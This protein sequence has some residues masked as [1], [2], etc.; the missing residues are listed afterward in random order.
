MKRI[1]VSSMMRKVSALPPKSAPA[2]GTNQISTPRYPVRKTIAS[3]RCG[4]CTF[5][6]ISPS[7]RA[8]TKDMIG[9]YTKAMRMI[10]TRMVVV[11]SDGKRVLA[12][13]MG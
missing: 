2:N 9:A 3:C 7:R 10:T 8:E 4:I 5:C 13:T 6:P 1:P 12:R 11:I